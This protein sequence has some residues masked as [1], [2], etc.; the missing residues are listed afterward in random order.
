MRL[1]RRSPQTRLTAAL[2]A[3]VLPT[4]FVLAL[5]L[6]PV[7]TAAQSPDVPHRPWRTITTENFRIHYLPETEAW[8]REIAAQMES[9]RDAVATRIGYA[10]PQVIDL[11]VEDPFNQPNGNAWP[12]LYTPAMRF[13]ATPPQPSSA[14]GSARGW[15]EILAVHEY[16][17]L[18][19]LLRPSRKPF[20]TLAA[21]FN[22][23][24]LS[25][26][27]GVPAWVSEGYATVIEGELT[28]AGR[29]NGAFRPMILRTLALE[30]YLPSYGELD[31]TGRFN[32]GAMRYL[33]GSAYLE[34]LQAA[35]GD[36][37]LPQLWRRVTPR[38]PREFP[39]AFTGI[40]GDA[41]AVLYGHFASEV[42]R[43][44]HEAADEIRARGLAQGELVQKW[45]WAV[46]TPAVSPDGSKL[47]VRRA[48]PE[49]GSRLL[50]LSTEPRELSAEDSAKQFKRYE[51]D[52][53]DVRPY[54]P[55]PRALKVEASLLPTNGY[56]YDNP[57][58]FRDGEHLLV[59]RAVPQSDGRLRLD[60]F[61]WSGNGDVDRITS[62]AGITMA[63]PLP[64]GDRAA[65]L[66]CGGGTCSL[67][68]VDLGSGEVTMLA[69]GGIDRPYAGVRVSP[70]GRR[71][72]ASVQDGPVWRLVVVDI[73]SGQVTRVGPQDNAIRHSPVW[74]NDSTLIAVSEAEGIATLERVPLRSGA[75]RVVVRTLT[76]AAAPEVGPDGRIWWLEMHGRGYD[77]RVSDPST[78]L[79]VGAPLSPEL[80]PVTQRVNRALALDFERAPVP[81]DKAYGFGPF[82]ASWTMATLG[83]AEGASYAGGLSMGDP[84]ARWSGYVIGGDAQ[85][86]GW[87]GG[88]ASFTY[89]GW[90]PAITLEAFRAEQ[91]PS[92]QWRLGSDTPTPF[93]L[94]YTG[95]L[96]ALS[97]QLITTHSV[98][99]LRVGFSLGDIESLQ[100]GSTIGRRVLFTEL[101]SRLRF[102]PSTKLS[103]ELGGAAGFQQVTLE[104]EAGGSAD[105]Q[106]TTAEAF[107]GAS[108]QSGAGLRVRARA[109]R[110][111]RNDTIFEYFLVGGAGSL[112]IDDAVLGNRV[113]YPS[114]PIFA[115]SGSEFGILSVETPGPVRL[116]HDWVAGGVD[117]LGESL[118]VVGGEWNFELPRIAVFRLPL[119]KAQ[120]GLS[121]A[122]NGPTRNATV[123]Y[124]G[125]RFVPW[126]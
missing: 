60:L 91:R 125:L 70:D 108:H 94:T 95:G 58:W 78:S 29:P 25:P 68:M 80:A 65:A 109:G 48:S 43:K 123:V 81:E 34:W 9:V 55:Y 121:H 56:A 119:G 42:T 93:D 6:T 13:W 92:E 30:G 118:R 72:A 114:L 79:D 88:Q 37:A 31:A 38:K 62:N 33:V 27:T 115:A 87:S 104:P 84:L 52:P 73:A 110:L 39:E 67:V 69:E 111:D 64:D 100:T 86:G 20:A 54:T 66:T 71:V 83:G 61:R 40:F 75:P 3:A 122:L 103:V 116:F 57:R 5:A 24:A 106:R 7:H 59:T 46:G 90:R 36:S 126:R 4:A 50:I 117:G 51:E 89:R 11:I 49:N 113:T 98:S 82:G 2:A 21:F 14:I 45:T 107:I 12:T 17:H 77:L 26:M 28:G 102:T 1:R 23:V 16:A 96:L 53:E 105:V 41:P 99:E 10:P 44:A 18:A 124:G 19:H 74:E 47:A 85:G 112:F 97:D 76:A 63:D 22:G 32:G 101:A 120:V 15:G 35:R 8:A